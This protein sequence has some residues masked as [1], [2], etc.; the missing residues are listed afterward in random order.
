MAP[1]GRYAGAMGFFSKLFS[2][3]QNDGSS[4]MEGGD[5]VGEGLEPLFAFI[6]LEDT[7]IA[8]EQEVRDR[9]T[10][11]FGLSSPVDVKN[12]EVSDSEESASIVFEI[13][14]QCYMAV[15]MNAPIPEED[16]RYAANNGELYWENA[17][18]QLQP[19]QAHLIVTALGTYP[20]QVAGALALSRCLIA[21]AEAQRALGIYWGHGSMAY[22]LDYYAKQLEGA[23]LE[24]E[25]LPITLWVGFLLSRNEDTTMDCYT[26]GLEF[27]GA[28]EVEIVETR[29]PFEEVMNL[30][31]GL[32]HYLVGHGDV[33]GD[34]DTVGG[35]E[36]RIPT[37]YQPSAIGR[38]EEVIRIDW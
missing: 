29:Q 22:P 8:S 24:L 18:D 17:W 34:G 11:W 13:E 12:L 5:A 10:H 16:L 27:F 21:L 14:G 25:N 37:S 28:K 1:L 38:D 33:I 36:Q 6:C 7:G 9:L 19:Q 3:G 32:S 35:D 23:D 15:L 2:R 31:V 30:I 4:A 26:D 20:S